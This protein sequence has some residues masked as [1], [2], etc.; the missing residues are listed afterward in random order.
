M[1]GF[2]LMPLVLL[3]AV[4]LVV[5]LNDMWGAALSSIGVGWCSFAA[6]RI[7]VIALD[8]HDQQ[9]LIAYPCAL[10][11]GVLALLAVF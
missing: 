1:L 2:S 4:G 9:L 8:M 5:R 7:F 3:S 6:S 11:Y 10:L